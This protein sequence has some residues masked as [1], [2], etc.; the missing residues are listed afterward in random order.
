APVPGCPNVSSVLPAGM[1]SET[2]PPAPSTVTTA[3]WSS[4]TVPPAGAWF[5]SD[6]SCAWVPPAKQSWPVQEL[7]SGMAI[8]G[9]GP[10]LYEGLVELQMLDDRLLNSVLV[11]NWVTIDDHAS[12]PF[13]AATLALKPLASGSRLSAPRYSDRSRA[14]LS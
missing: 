14:P 1:L 13:K 7:P 6:W 4:I 8:A 12:P 5:S 9:A 2:P 10:K 3:C 11:K